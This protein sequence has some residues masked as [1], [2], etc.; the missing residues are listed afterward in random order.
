[1]AEVRKTSTQVQQQK[2]KGLIA[3]CEEHPQAKAIVVSQDSRERLVKMNENIEITILP[4]Q[5]FLAKLW[6][7][8]II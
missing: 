1:M 7:G 2:L 8:E 4:W 6:A 5:V 3:F